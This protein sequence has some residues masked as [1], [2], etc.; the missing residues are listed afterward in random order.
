[1]SKRTTAQRARQESEHR[2]KG[3]YA[4]VNPCYACGKS[5][6]VN[7]FS[8]P[9]T[10]SLSPSGRGWHDTA[11]CLCKKCAIATEDMLEPSEFE[12]YKK[13]FGEASDD[14]WDQVDKQR[15]S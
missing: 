13:Q 14:A 5:A 12:E 3:K 10:D 2:L 4:K 9:L 7:Y 8:H 6:G 15:H 11:L 1:M